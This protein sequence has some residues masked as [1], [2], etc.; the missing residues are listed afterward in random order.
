[1]S[2]TT[3]GAGMQPKT[4]ALLGSLFIGGAP[5]GSSPEAR[6]WGRLPEKWG[7]PIPRGAKARLDGALS[8]PWHGVGSGQDGRSL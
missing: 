1:M 3:G 5:A 7:C 8:S 2:P 6:H 4:A